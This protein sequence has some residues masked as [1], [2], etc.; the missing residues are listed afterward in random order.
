MAKLTLE[1]KVAKYSDQS[2][3]PDACWPWIRAVSGVGYGVVFA[4]GRCISAHRAAWSL[5]NGPIPDGLLVCHH[6]DNRRCVNPRHLFLGTASDNTADMMRKGRDF[7]PDT[8]GERNGVAKL[9]NEKVTEIRRRYRS[10][11]VSQ[12]KLAAEYEVS[13][14][15]IHLALSRMTWTEAT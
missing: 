9:S 7:R 8:R 11:D 6:C 10:E 14:K 5:I 3:G 15:A 12:R 2:G 1:G 4:D 13:Q